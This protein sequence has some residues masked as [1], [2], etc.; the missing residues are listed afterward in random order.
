[1]IFIKV[2]LWQPIN[3]SPDFT[4]ETMAHSNRRKQKVLGREVAIGD[5]EAIAY[6][7]SPNNLKDIKSWHAILVGAMED[8]R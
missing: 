6:A 7:D 5:N 1:M 4:S 2:E 3:V 8:N